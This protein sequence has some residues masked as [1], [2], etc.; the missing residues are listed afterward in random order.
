MDLWSRFRDGLARTRGR[1]GQALGSLLPL[2]GPVDAAARE[3]LEQALLEA[4]VGP[5]TAERMIE[6]AAQRMRGAR[7]TDLRAAL[8]SVATEMLSRPAPPLEPGPASAGSP[9]V[10]LLVGVNGSGKTTLAGKLAA[11]LARRGR[12][13]LLVAADTFRAAAREQLEVWA[14]RA[15]VGMVGGRDGSDPAAAVHDGLE[16]ARARGSDA[17]LVDTAGRLHTRHNLMAELAKIGRVCARLVPGAPHH[18]LLVLDA[19]IGQNGLA[20]A[21]EFQRSIAVTSLAV[22]KLDG[23]ARGG[24]VLAIADQLELPISLV[25]IGEGLD[26]WVSFDAAAFAQGLF[27]LP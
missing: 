23:S 2:Q 10:L 7:D 21:R 16:A 9:W 6:L 12:R 3:R 4:D 11:H 8:E 5:A 25:G 1:L 13:P 27:E 20:Q 19:T 26:D 24:V 15:G 18:V 22:N 14:A 17:V